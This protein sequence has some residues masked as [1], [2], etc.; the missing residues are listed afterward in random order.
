MESHSL[1]MEVL[2]SFPAVADYSQECEV[3][4]KEAMKLFHGKIIVLDDDPTG[5]QTVHG[6]A[7]YTDWEEETIQ[8]GFL[9]EK[10]MFFILTNSRS[11]TKNETREVH[12]MIGTRIGK[13]AREMAIP[14][15]VISRSDSTLRGHYPTETN[16]LK[17]SLEFYDKRYVGEIFCPFFLEGGRYT[18][19]DIHYVQFENRL[20][21]VGETE[22]SKDKSFSYV[23]SDLKDFIQEKNDQPL[24][25]DDIVSI[26]LE[27]LRGLHLT[28]ILEAITRDNGYKR[29][30][31]NAI[32]YDDLRVFVSVL[33]EAIH[34][35]NHYMIR[36]AASLP[37]VLG[38]IEEKPLLEKKD[39]VSVPTMMGGLVIIG[40]HVKKTT[41]QLEY[42]RKSKKDLCY[43]EFDVSKY[44]EYQGLERE[45]KRI[46]LESEK[47]IQQ[48][49]TVVVYTS[50][51]LLETSTNNKDQILK[52]SV[53]ISDA[54]TSIVS[55][56]SIKPRF[57]LAKGGITS[58]DIGTKALQVKKAIVMGQ[59]RK[60]IPVWMTGKESKFSGMPYIIF[61]GNVGTVE[62]LREIVEDLI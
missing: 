22:Y 61:P 11:F 18:F 39:I 10:S 56:I 48:G 7:V 44:Y 5:I 47:E 24:I 1:S 13:I 17:Q 37:K 2:N 27:D 15:L 21:P 36:C 57:I 62:N 34:R 45:V 25:S 31:V 42:L 58:S 30:I 6:V 60:G 32:S 49:R 50:R 51:E 9:S 28:K 54:V 43:L 8:E 14:F 12:Q 59:I 38:M 19:G 23:S 53:Q 52:T 41:E 3:L 40:S 20:Y 46:V 26:T 35:G 55:M 16:V 29:I 4:Y 33:M